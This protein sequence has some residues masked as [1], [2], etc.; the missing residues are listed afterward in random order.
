MEFRLH[1]PEGDGVAYGRFDELGQ[2]FA[3]PE[4]GLELGA[5]LR[6]VLK[7]CEPGMHAAAIEANESELLF[8]KERLLYDFLEHSIL[9]LF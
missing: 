1:A 6:G 3:L 7:T 5:Q 4:Y 2:G 9:Y 8:I